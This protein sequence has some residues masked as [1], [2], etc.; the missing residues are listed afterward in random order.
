MAHDHSN[1]GAGLHGGPG[2]GPHLATGAMIVASSAPGRGALGRL[3][4][5]PLVMFALGATAGYFAYKYRKEIV[6]AAMRA[7]EMGKD[8]VMNT[9]ETL[10]DLMEEAKERAEG[11]PTG[12]GP[13]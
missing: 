1:H 11:G 7:S 10:E 4:T 13:A 2:L 5:H 6:D 8:Y 12:P 9:R 3:L